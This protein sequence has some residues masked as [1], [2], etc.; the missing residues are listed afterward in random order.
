MIIGDVVSA[1]KRDKVDNVA[2][3]TFTDSPE[4]NGANDS[5]YAVLSLGDIWSHAGMRWTYPVDES[6][7]PEALKPDTIAVPV[8]KKL[9]T[10][11]FGPLYWRS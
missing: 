6:R 9:Y 7:I 1:V 5:A 3:R 2:Y 10:N 4:T 8:T 11:L